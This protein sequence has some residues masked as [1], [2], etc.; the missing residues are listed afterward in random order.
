M[1]SLAFLAIMILVVRLV[2][3]SEIIAAVGFA[4]FRDLGRCM[5]IGLMKVA[6]KFLLRILKDDRLE[7]LRH[8]L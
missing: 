4:D 8:T 6:A 3:I 2:V 5:E 1:A 7:F